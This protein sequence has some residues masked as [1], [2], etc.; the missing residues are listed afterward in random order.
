[1]A[2]VT[3]TLDEISPLETA[4]VRRYFAGAAVTVGNLVYLDTAGKVQPADANA[5]ASSQA[6]G[7]A[8]AFG[9]RGATLCA[10]ND[11]VD[12]CIGGPVWVGASAGMTI[13]GR[14]Y[15]SPT[16]GGFDQTVTTTPGEFP[17]IIGFAEAAQ[18]LFI[19]RQIT[20][21][22]VVPGP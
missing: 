18:I 13:P 2:V 21:P 11:P 4:L 5:I 1:M 15:V 10:A 14:V 19:Q 3:T 22:V 12:V 17:F 7:I 6:I 8:V 16:A 9:L 20:I